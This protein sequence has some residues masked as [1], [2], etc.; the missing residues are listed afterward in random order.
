[1]NRYG[2]GHSYIV[3]VPPL[4]ICNSKGSGGR[5][6]DRGSFFG[7]RAVTSCSLMRGKSDVSMVRAAKAQLEHVSNKG[8][9][10]AP[11]QSV[12]FKM[13]IAYTHVNAHTYNHTAPDN[14]LLRSRPCFALLHKQACLH[15]SHLGSYSYFWP[16]FILIINPCSF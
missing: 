9:G 11:S 5:T 14:L 16:S 13:G 15:Q 3:I 8:D 12:R 4:Y 2:L 7:Y 1:M 6:T 10:P